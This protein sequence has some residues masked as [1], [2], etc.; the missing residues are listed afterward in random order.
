MEVE[1]SLNDDTRIC[2]ECGEH[3]QVLVT[4]GDD[5]ELELEICGLCL[6]K[7]LGM[8]VEAGFAASRTPRA[9]DR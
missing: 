6:A 1:I 7:A 5:F 9:Q 2:D 4:L 8:A 3:V